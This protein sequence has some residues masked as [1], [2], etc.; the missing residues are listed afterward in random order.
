MFG[1]PKKSAVARGRIGVSLARDSVAIAVVR[2]DGAA[3][4]PLLERCELLPL[5]QGAAPAAIAEVLRGAGLPTMPVSA[6][7]GSGQYQMV[8]VEAPDVPPAELRAAMRWR[9]REAI[10]FPVEEAVIDVIE[11]PAQNRASQGRMVYAVAARRQQVD[12]QAGAFHGQAQ[13]DVIDVPELALRNLTQLLPASAAGVAL[14]HLH[15]S[16]ATVVLVRGGTFYFS[17]QMALHATLDPAGHDGE[18]DAAGVALEL[19][20]SLDYYERHFDQP[21]IG[22]VAIAP[23]GARA[24]A[25]V[26]ALARE[27]GLTVVE[28]DLNQLLRCAAPVT[29]PAQDA[30]LLAVGAALRV[31]RRS[32]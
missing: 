22:N 32:L 25:L 4:N 13:F 19:Q 23:A 11:L 12:Q 27:T 21:P 26:E 5:P 14:L 8:L 15:E 9:L 3:S 28:L 29:A 6:V 17:R 20:R 18:I 16:T 31:E 1:F 10:D 7:L 24:A 2:R 30:A